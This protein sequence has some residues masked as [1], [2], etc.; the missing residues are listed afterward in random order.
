MALSFHQ[1]DHGQALLLLETYMQLGHLK[2]FP[3][4]GAWL[5]LFGKPLLK[6]FLVSHEYVKDTITLGVEGWQM[7][8]QK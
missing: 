4:N 2:I 3:S 8:I 5:A 6:A 1:T 7:V